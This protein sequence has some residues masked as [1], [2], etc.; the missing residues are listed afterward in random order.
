VLVAQAGRVVCRARRGLGSLE[1]AAPVQRDTIYRI[2]SM[3]KPVMAVAALALAEAGKLALDDP[4]SRYIPSFAS[5]TVNQLG[6]GDR[7]VTK[8]ART[9]MTVR[10]L[11]T[12]SSGLTYCEGNPGAVARLYERERTDFGPGDGPL[13]EVVDRVARIPLLFDP[14]SSWAYGVSSDVLGRVVEVAGGAR[15]DRF[16][17][18]TILA[19]LAMAG[20]AWRAARMGRVRE[21]RFL[22]RRGARD[23][24]HLHDAARPVRPL[25][26][27]HASREACFRSKQ[28]SAVCA[29]R[30][31]GAPADPPT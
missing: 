14:G 10:H 30:Q 4:V 5:L 25:P 18:E 22:G 24:R 27:R 6:T 2:Y 11:L 9:A 21:H 29:P 23:H 28:D 13:A 15:L 16:V 17:H 20:T 3:T 7:I 19:P 1:Q 31:V 12:H 8:P 26:H